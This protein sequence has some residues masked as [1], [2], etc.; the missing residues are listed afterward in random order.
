MLLIFYK[1]NFEK[2]IDN[3]Y[4]LIVF[5][6]FSATFYLKSKLSN[7][8]S[9]KVERF[10][11]SLSSLSFWLSAFLLIK[12]SLSFTSDSQ[13]LFISSISLLCLVVTI[14][15][16]QRTLKDSVFSRRMAD[17]QLKSNHSPERLA[18]ILENL[19][20]LIRMRQQGDRE[21]ILVISGY[22]ADLRKGLGSCIDDDTPL[23]IKAFQKTDK[24][25]LTQYKGK[26]DA[27]MIEYLNRQYLAGICKYRGNIR[28]QISYSIFLRDFLRN[29]LMAYQQVYSIL[30]KP[31]LTLEQVFMVKQLKDQLDNEDDFLDFKD[32]DDQ[33]EEQ[34]EDVIGIKEGRGGNS[35]AGRLQ[36]LKIPVV[37]KE[38]LLSSLVTLLEKASIRYLNLWQTLSD[39][40]P[41]I[42][43]IYQTAKTSQIH[44][45]ACLDFWEKNE[46]KL[47]TI[48]SAQFVYG[49]FLRDG[50]YLREQGDEI[51]E[52]AVREVKKRMRDKLKIKNLD[53]M[54]E[55]GDIQ[56]PCFQLMKR[57]GVSNFSFKNREQR[58]KNSHSLNQRD[59]TIFCKF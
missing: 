30:N 8:I 12:D 6:T 33:D 4:I 48:V 34:S 47:V 44:I 18:E 22:V 3:H 20:F 51:L 5:L 28:L 26:E 57:L 46:A 15:A 35:R 1:H 56:L 14:I 54:A 10:D 9:R 59:F 37:V 49:K 29:R 21:A 13:F 17:T 42:S 23:L 39:P 53:H 45:R 19:S 16:K 7:N 40:N 41:Q 11:A 58:A 27:L 43:K 55:L 25:F 2:K 32:E 31:D 36:K 50:I 38:R 24:Q 52:S